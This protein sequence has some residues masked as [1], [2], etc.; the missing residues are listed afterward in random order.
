[1]LAPGALNENTMVS[2]PTSL[3]VGNHHH[4]EATD[5]L[6]SFLLL[7]PVSSSPQLDIKPFVI[8]VGKL[9]HLTESPHQLPSID[10]VIPIRFGLDHLSLLAILGPVWPVQTALSY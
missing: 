9:S 8:S 10:S 5:D 6:V 4:I 1:M 3:V 7:V 2:S